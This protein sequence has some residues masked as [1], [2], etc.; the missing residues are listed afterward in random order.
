MK[1]AN[2]YFIEVKQQRLQML[3]CNANLRAWGIL[4][5]TARVGWNSK[6]NTFL[7]ADLKSDCYKYIIKWF[8]KKYML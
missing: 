6:M 5:A 1:D 3:T 7:R 4:L 2:Y 8:E